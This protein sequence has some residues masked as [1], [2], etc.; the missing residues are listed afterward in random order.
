MTLP[1]EAEWQECMEKVRK[2]NA[3]LKRAVDELEKAAEEIKAIRDER[4]TSAPIRN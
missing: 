3:E 1:D 4:I 2:A